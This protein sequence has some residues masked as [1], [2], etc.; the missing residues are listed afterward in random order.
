MTNAVRNNRPPE[1]TEAVF[2]QLTTVIA[3]IVTKAVD[4]AVEKKLGE[5]KSHTLHN[6]TRQPTA[7][8][9]FKLPKASEGK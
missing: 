5:G 9:G 1:M 4:E 7:A 8:G 6:G 2:N 3:D